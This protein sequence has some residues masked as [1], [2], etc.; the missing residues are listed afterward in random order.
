MHRNYGLS[1]ALKAL[2]DLGRMLEKGSD[3]RNPSGYVLSIAARGTEGGGKRGF[4]SKSWK[5][6]AFC[7]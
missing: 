1:A 3:I 7:A 5:T 6:A 4:A 2:F